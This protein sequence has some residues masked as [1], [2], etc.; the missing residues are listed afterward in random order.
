MVARAGASRLG[1]SGGF[2]T[3]GGRRAGGG[4]GN[5]AEDWRLTGATPGPGASSAAASA[6]TASRS[7][8]LRGAFTIALRWPLGVSTRSHHTLAPTSTRSP[9]GPSSNPTRWSASAHSEAT[10][11]AGNCTRGAPASARFHASARANNTQP[12]TATGRG[13]QARDAGPRRLPPSRSLPL[14]ASCTPVFAL[15]VTSPRASPPRGDGV[16]LWVADGPGWAEIVLPRGG[17][18]AH[19]AF[20]PDGR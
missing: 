15:R 18:S 13:P 19:L 2:S 8:R 1:G 3:G 6:A 14:G 9:P 4:I 17:P 16:R 11:C 7:A 20:H 10:S 5:A 12:R